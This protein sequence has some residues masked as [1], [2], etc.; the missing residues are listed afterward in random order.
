MSDMSD[1]EN[2]LDDETVEV[3]IKREGDEKFAEEVEIKELEAKKPLPKVEKIRI[4]KEVEVIE[5]KRPLTLAEKEEIKKEIE[6][7]E[8]EAIQE[9]F[10]NASHNNLGDISLNVEQDFLEFAGLV[11]IKLELTEISSYKVAFANEL[12]THM[13]E[14]MKVE[15]MQKIQSKL[16][17]LISTKQ[18]AM[19]NKGK[20][21]NK[22]KKKGP[23]LKGLGKNGEED[24]Y[25]DFQDDDYNEKANY[26]YKE[27]DDD[28][29]FM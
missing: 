11:N 4:K 16:K 10:G 13:I 19:K 27:E 17:V 15:E 7:K 20:K 25:A 24:I 18:K 28:D 26:T 8:K 6:R 5:E 22:K 2:E 3:E 23:S 21:K 9:L 1:W 12:L 29:D 14:N